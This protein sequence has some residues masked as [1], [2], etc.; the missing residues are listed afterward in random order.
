[1]KRRPKRLLDRLPMEHSASTMLQHRG[2]L[3]LVDL[4]L[5]IG[6]AGALWRTRLPTVLTKEELRQVVTA[7]GPHQ[8]TVGLSTQRFEKAMVARFPTGDH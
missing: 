3:R 5:H 1:M 2:N 7:P 4:D 8:H 6:L